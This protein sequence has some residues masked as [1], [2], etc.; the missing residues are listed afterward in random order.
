MSDPA[1]SSPFSQPF[2]SIWQAQQAG[3]L[4]GSFLNIGP[5]I[6]RAVGSTHHL[7]R[8]AT[9]YAYDRSGEYDQLRTDSVNHS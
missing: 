7:L 2:A 8:T 9:V 5:S 1:N 6:S 4:L 3:G